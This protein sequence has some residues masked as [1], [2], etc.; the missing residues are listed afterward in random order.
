V[1]IP[2]NADCGEWTLRQLR[3]VDKANNSSFLSMDA[4]QVGRVSFLVSGGG[5]CDAEP[6]VVDALF[7][8]PA[9][10]SNANAAEITVIV[11]AHDEGSGVASLSGWID[12][13]VAT[14]GQAPRIYFECMP[15]PR[16]KDGPMTARITVPQ[17]AAKGLWKVTL[18]QV[19]DK[20]RNT[21]AY[22]RDDPALKDATFT[23]D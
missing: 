9:T 15:D 20:A 23:V 17:F 6:P 13:P 1:R 14:N 21:R 16:D 12:G 2:E 4:P 19:A 10:V 22:N 7:F 11:R 5:G 3:V 8:S 18:A